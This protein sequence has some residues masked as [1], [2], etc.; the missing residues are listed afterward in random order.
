MEMTNIVIFHVETDE[1]FMAVVL[2]SYSNALLCVAKFPH[3]KFELSQL[4]ER[5]ASDE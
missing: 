5:H 2:Y 4:A 3:G 1:T